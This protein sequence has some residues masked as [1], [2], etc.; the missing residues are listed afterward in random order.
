MVIDRTIIDRLYPR[1][2]PELAAAFASQAEEKFAKYGIS[3]N[4]NRLYH[5]LAQVGHESGGLTVDEENLNYRAER[6]CQ[7]WPTRFPTVADAEPYAQNPKAL[8]EKVYGGRMGNGKEGTGDGWN[9]RGRGLIQIT[10]RE[11]YQSVAK[12]TGLDLV[13]QPDLAAAPGHALEVACG[14]WKWKNLNP[15]C[16]TG[17]FRQVTKL[18]NGGVIG[19]P[20]RKAWLAKV[21]RI[22]GELPPVD[23]QPSAQIVVAVQRELLRRGYREVGAADGLVGPHTLSAVTRLRKENGLPA[24]GIDDQ[25]LSFLHLPL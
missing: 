15:V 22:L 12:E 25:L 5:F 11:G 21:E 9:Y 8:A 16:D 19:L 24:G 3:E 6:M 18:I 4:S 13:N 1:A 20:E 23:A 17:D 2:K 7:V 14:F 10:G